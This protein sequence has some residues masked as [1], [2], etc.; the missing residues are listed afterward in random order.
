MTIF[1]DNTDSPKASRFRV[2][3]NGFADRA[4]YPT[5]HDAVGSIPPTGVDSLSFEIYDEIERQYVWTLP[6]QNDSRAC[7]APYAVWANGHYTG[8]SFDSL[9]EA[10]A[11]ILDRPLGGESS[12]FN[13]ETCVYMRGL[14][15]AGQVEESL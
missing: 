10:V 14:P 1:T 5:L 6:R 15:R 2:L 11:S 13:G 7:P 12:V 8:L 3:V 9:A 4:M